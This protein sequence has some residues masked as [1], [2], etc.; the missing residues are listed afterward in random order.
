LI[1]LTISRLRAGE[2]NVSANPLFTEMQSVISPGLIAARPLCVT[3]G[4]RMILGFRPGDPSRIA[5]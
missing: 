1:S 2:D 5:V 4:R 3:F